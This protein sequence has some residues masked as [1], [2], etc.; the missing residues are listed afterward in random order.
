MIPVVDNKLMYIVAI[1]V[2]TIVTALLIN[3][4]KAMG[5]RKPAANGST[6]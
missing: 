4:L 3:L 2:G 6:A 1:I 5:N